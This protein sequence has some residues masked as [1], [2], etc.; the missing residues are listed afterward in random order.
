ML[1]VPDKSVSRSPEW[2]GKA[3]CCFWNCV[4]MCV[5]SLPHWLKS[6]CQKKKILFN[7]QKTLFL[8]V[9]PPYQMLLYDCV[10]LTVRCL[11]D[12]TV[13]MYVHDLV[14]YASRLWPAG[15][16]HHDGDNMRPSLCCSGLYWSGDSGS[17]TRGPNS[18]DNRCSGNE[19]RWRRGLCHLVWVQKIRITL[20]PICDTKRALMF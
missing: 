11:Y 7:L 17:L 19:L 12:M 10:S 13:C 16:D 8:T 1:I 20:N 15:W 3:A 2:K 18:A 14:F 4:C 6:A 9:F 5:R